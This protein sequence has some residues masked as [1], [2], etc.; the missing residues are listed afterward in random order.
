MAATSAAPI[1]EISRNG[2]RW[3]WMAIALLFLVICAARISSTVLDDDNLWLAYLGIPPSAEAK[4]IERMVV[5]KTATQ[6]GCSE[7]TFRLSLRDRY[8]ANYAGYAALNQWTY[9]ALAAIEEGGTSGAVLA[10]VVAK[11]LVFVLVSLALIAAAGHIED[12]EVNLAAA[13][14]LIAMAGF[15]WAVHSGALPSVWIADVGNPLKALSRLAYSF[16]FT[17]EAHSIFGLTPRNAVLTLFAAAMALRWNRHALAASCLIFCAGALHQ[18]YGGIAVLMFAA[19]TAASRPADLQNWKVRLVLTAALLAALLRD[20]F[21]AANAFILWGSAALLVVTA[22][23]AFGLI[24]SRSYQSQRLRLLGKF[25]KEEVVID[26]VVM[27]MICALITIVALALA[28]TATP[29]ARLYFWSDLTFRIWS[30]ARFPFFVAI[31]V[32]LIRRVHDENAALPLV[33][34]AFL[35]AFLTIIQIDRKPAWA[36]PAPLQKELA[37]LDDPELELP[38]G[39]GIVYSHLIAVSSGVEAPSS[40]RRRLSTLPILCT[41]MPI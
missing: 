14:A 38:A 29:S 3:L 25:E 11:I 26:A 27:T 13:G 31:G 17:S 1:V 4:A 19:A 34:A 5:N 10:A 33:G 9:Q 20:R 40:L 36:G 28:P 15:D 22:A 39:E 18:T 7:E 32:L 21:F 2:L 24:Q 41:P 16:F 8:G 35:L 30:F 6:P 37:G 12:R 23:A